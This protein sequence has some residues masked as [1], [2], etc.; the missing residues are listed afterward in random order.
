[1][2]EQQTKKPIKIHVKRK[3]LTTHSNASGVKRVQYSLKEQKV[4]KKGFLH[5]F[6]LF[7]ILLSFLLAVF[8]FQGR[9]LERLEELGQF[10]LE[11]PPLPGYFI[12]ASLLCPLLSYFL[13]PSGPRLTLFRAVL[14]RLYASIM[15]TPVGWIA[16]YRLLQGLYRFDW[17]RAFTVAFL[18]WC[19]WVI[20]A[21]LAWIIPNKISQIRAKP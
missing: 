2:N 12:A 8:A 19:A 13:V 5:Y 11:A 3:V 15:I 1:M 10:M 17:A 6:W 9:M 14:W 20:I 18:S 4:E 16:E 21:F 7:F